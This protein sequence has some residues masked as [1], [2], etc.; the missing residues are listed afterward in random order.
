VALSDVRLQDGLLRLV[1]P[2]QFLRASREG[3]VEYLSLNRPD[4]R[5]ALNEVVLDELHRWADGLRDDTSVRVAVLAG[6][7]RHFC[8]GADIEWMR[9]MGAAAE[10]DNIADAER[11]SSTFHALDTLPVPLIGR[12][13]GAAIGGG[14]GLAAV[15]DM[16]VAA[17]DAQF[18]FSEVRLGILPAAISPFVLAKIGGSAA[19][20]L[21]LTGSRFTA[22][23][24]CQLGLV[25]RVVPQAELDQVVSGWITDLMAGAPGAISHAKRLIRTVAGRR[26]EDVASF[27]SGAIAEQRMSPEGREG[28]SAFLEK[29]APAWSR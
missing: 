13:H 10:S 18:A 27:T 11:L 20:E 15:C 19:R 16:V 26:Y 17:D 25:H 21:F 24:A 14:M 9:R 6:S 3:A 12:V 8:A 28:L 7:G 2:F 5:N 1:M 4:L 29:R 23:R 22:T